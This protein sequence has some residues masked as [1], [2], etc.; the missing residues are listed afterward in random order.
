MFQFQFDDKWTTC[1]IIMDMTVT[2]IG[3]V[4][5]PIHD[6]I[7]DAQFNIRTFDRTENLPPMFVNDV[8]LGENGLVRFLS[9]R[10]GVYRIASVTRLPTI[11]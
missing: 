10:E 4:D 7:I 2:V 3:Y 5:V 11:M 8:E 9:N 6:T 1:V